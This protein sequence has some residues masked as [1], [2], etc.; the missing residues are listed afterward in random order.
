[1]V[2][3]RLL[4]HPRP[5]ATCALLGKCHKYGMPSSHAQVMSYAFTT[6]LLMHLH[7]RRN[8]KNVKN[9]APSRSEVIELIEL[10]LLAALGALVGIARVYLG[11]HS[12]DQVLAGVGLG[13]I[14]SVVW[15]WLIQAAVHSIGLAK[16]IQ[17]V[18]SVLLHLRNSWEEPY[19][20][21][22]SQS[23]KVR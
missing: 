6:A 19:V 10:V 8:R 9:S 7:R 1:M 14:F 2:V 18:F 21:G 13:S 4:R 3:K 12:A 23:K 17:N 5:Q 16:S 22:T 20:H 11:Y 15:F